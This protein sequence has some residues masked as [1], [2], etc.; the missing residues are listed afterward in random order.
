MKK[1]LRPG[2]VLFAI[3]A[4]FVI[5]G[6]SALAQS[7]W[8]LT[9]ADFR[10]KQVDLT[11]IDDK[12]ATFADR[13]IVRFDDLLLLDRTLDPGQQ[14]GGG[15]A[16]GKFILY[17]SGGDQFRGEP[18]KL[19]GETLYWSSPA[20]GEMQVPLRQVTSLVRATPQSAA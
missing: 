16:A 4:L 2:F 3:S 5:C 14:A 9:T 17:L 11:S 1:E 13:S 12:G 18:A 20:I 19:E 10:S 8:T 15:G 7:K 6:S